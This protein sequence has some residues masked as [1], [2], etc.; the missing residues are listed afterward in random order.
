MPA[1]SPPRITAIAASVSP[2]FRDSGALN[3][4]TPSAIASTPVSAV[5]PEANARSSRNS[6]IGWVTRWGITTAGTS[7]AMNRRVAPQRISAAKQAMKP[8]VG[9]AKM[10]PDS[11]SPRRLATVITAI[12]TTPSATR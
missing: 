12:A 9:R 7:P 5:H 10:R 4:G 2:A 11:R 8:Y 3:A 6:V 1:N